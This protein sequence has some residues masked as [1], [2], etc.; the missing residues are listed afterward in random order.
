V[1][2]ACPEPVEGRGARASS[3][4]ARADTALAPHEH[5]PLYRTVF[6]GREQ[7]VRQL[8][9]AFDAAMSGQGGLVMVVARPGLRP[10]STSARLTHLRSVSGVMPH[11]VAMD[12]IAAH[13][14]GYSPAVLQHQ[15]HRPLP[16]LH[17]IPPRSSDGSILSQFGASTFPGAVHSNSF[18]TT[19]GT[20]STTFPLYTAPPSLLYPTL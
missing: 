11:F 7:E 16:D 19:I 13:C 4:S 1:L 8:H 18:L 14:D 20:S 12:V 15:A 2:S 5:D 10:A 3:A 9:T 6:V 17:W